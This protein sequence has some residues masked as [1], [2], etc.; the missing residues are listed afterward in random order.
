MYPSLE[1]LVK[2]ACELYKD[3][4]L[5]PSII[6]SWVKDGWYVSIVRWRGPRKELARQVLF[7]ITNPDLEAAYAEALRRIS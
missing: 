2:R 6:T 5:A 3:D 7:G 4:T 1:P